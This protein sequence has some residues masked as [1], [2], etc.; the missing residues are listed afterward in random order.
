MTPKGLRSISRI[1]LVAAAVGAGALLLGPFAR[2]EERILLTD[3]EAH[4]LGFYGLSLLCYVAFPHRRRNDLAASLILLA[5]ASELV[6]AMVGRDGDL[7]DWVADV[8]GVSLTLAP[9]IAENMRRAMREAP[10]LPLSRALARADRRRRASA[11]P[12]A[13]AP[14]RKPR[15]VD[16]PS[17]GRRHVGGQAA[18]RHAAP[19]A[20][21]ADA[22]EILQ[23]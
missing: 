23:T 14:A 3:K 13:V 19:T 2:I 17:A 8:A 15:F 10:N 12:G 16:E 9:L 1:C 21:Q 6:Q 4:L 20:A 22:A 5:G 18:R 7:W 11:D